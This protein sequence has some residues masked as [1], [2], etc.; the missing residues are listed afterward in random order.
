MHASASKGQTGDL[1]DAAVVL[2]ATA[3]GR[4]LKKNYTNRGVGTSRTVP[5][6]HRMPVPVRKN[7]CAEEEGEALRCF[8]SIKNT[9]PQRVAEDAATAGP[10]SALPAQCA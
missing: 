4:R 7:A 10:L 9:F 6:Q 3:R 5:Y 1:A 8:L 2:E